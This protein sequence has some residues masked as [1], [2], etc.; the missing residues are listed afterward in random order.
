[1]QKLLKV[2]TSEIALMT[3]CEH[4]SSVSVLVNTK[5]HIFFI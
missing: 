1:M 2:L 5:A 3:F 4:A